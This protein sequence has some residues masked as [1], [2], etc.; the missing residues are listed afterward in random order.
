LSIESGVGVSG[1]TLA[2]RM[3]LMNGNAAIEF[4]VSGKVP[5]GFTLSSGLPIP[6]ESEFGLIGVLALYSQ[7]GDAFQTSHVR[8]LLAIR[9]RIGYLMHVDASVSAGSRQTDGAVENPTGA[10]F[11]G[12]PTRI[13]AFPS[14]GTNSVASA[15]GLVAGALA[16]PGRCAREVARGEV[17]PATAQAKAVRYLSAGDMTVSR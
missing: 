10:T 4:G 14:A 3:P 8:A 5:P 17:R 7:Q 16:S 9:S 13:S 1:W 6:L 15:A 12:P 2:N 11:R